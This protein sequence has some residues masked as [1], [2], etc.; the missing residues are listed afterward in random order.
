MVNLGQE[1]LGTIQYSKKGEEF[2]IQEPQMVAL[3]IEHL[4]EVQFLEDTECLGLLMTQTG[5]S[6]P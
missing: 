5:V 2:K 1:A 4:P 6:F 3:H